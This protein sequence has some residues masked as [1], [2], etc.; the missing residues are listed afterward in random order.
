MTTSLIKRVRLPAAA[1]CFGLL[2]GGKVCAGDSYAPPPMQVLVRTELPNV[3]PPFH[4]AFVTSGTNKFAFLIP[5]G[6]QVHNDPLHGRINLCNVEG[7]RNISFTVLDPTPSE[8]RELG[9]D[10]YRE[11]VLNSF[12]NA[13]I[14]EENSRVA[15]GHSGPAFDIQWKSAGIV[16]HTRLVFVATAAG[17][18]EFTACTSTDKFPELDTDFS[19]VLGT[20]C[21]STNGKLE[22]PMVSDQL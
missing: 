12:P 1:L 16:Q 21:F 8:G 19:L 18:L 5:D 22:V 9:E 11:V 10:V 3:Q 6:L 7:N 17:V 4:R 14:L 13:K 2:F 20:F 15:A